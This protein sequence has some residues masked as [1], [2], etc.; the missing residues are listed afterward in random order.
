MQQV[1]LGAATFPFLMSLKSAPLQKRN[2]NQNPFRLLDACEPTD[3]SHQER[4]KMFPM[5][6]TYDPITSLT[7]V[8]Q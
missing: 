5:I 6:I 8:Q 1:D 2:R 7:T 4:R 3:M